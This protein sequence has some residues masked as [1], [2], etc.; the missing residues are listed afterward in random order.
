MRRLAYTA[1]VRPSGGGCLNDEGEKMT[2]D[3]SAMRAAAEAAIEHGEKIGETAWYEK[4]S[5]QGVTCDIIGEDDDAHIAGCSPVTI[6]ELIARVERAEA[7]ARALIHWYKPEVEGLKADYHPYD[8][9][10]MPVADFVKA[11]MDSGPQGQLDL[12]PDR[13][14]TARVAS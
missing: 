2:C 11:E 6:L 12:S 3:I 10:M 1:P 8:T 5:L 13:G 4:G 7:A 14:N 9:L